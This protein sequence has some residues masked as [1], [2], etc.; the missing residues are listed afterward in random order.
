MS[1]EHAGQDGVP[2]WNRNVKFY[3]GHE[4]YIQVYRIGSDLRYRTV[5]TIHRT[6]NQAHA[7]PFF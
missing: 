2:L 6:G 7:Q 4:Q 5:E 1:I 3:S